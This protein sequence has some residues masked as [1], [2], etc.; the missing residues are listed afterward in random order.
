MNTSPHILVISRTDDDRAY[1]ADFFERTPFGKQDF[2][3][4]KF[5]PSDKYDFIVFDCRTTPVY[6]VEDFVKLPQEIQD[7]FFL[8]ERYLNE[9]TKFILFFGRYYHNLNYERC[10]SANSKFTLFARIRELIE[11]AKHFSG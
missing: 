7:H 10:P 9:S 11:F 1:M 6:K 8:L 2:V 5:V 4:N 3:V